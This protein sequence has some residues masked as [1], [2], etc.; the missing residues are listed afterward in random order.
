MNHRTFN[1]CPHDIERTTLQFTW[2]S[3]S[4]KQSHQG[5][6]EKNICRW[7]FSSLTAVTLM[8]NIGRKKK[9]NIELH[10]VL[11][12]R[13]V[14]SR[15]NWQRLCGIYTPVHINQ[16]KLTSLRL[17]NWY[18]SSNQPWLLWYYTIHRTRTCGIASGSVR[19]PS[20]HSR[21][22]RYPGLSQNLS[23]IPEKQIKW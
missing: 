15:E 13:Y 11:A 4:L 19:S 9:F 1:W 14:Q 2:P 3:L 20:Y 18:L 23:H 16:R 5:N 22:T 6:L 10:N 8:C 12:S 7:E 21:Y 17:S